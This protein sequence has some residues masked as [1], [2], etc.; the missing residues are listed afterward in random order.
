MDKAKYK[1]VLKGLEDLEE[2]AILKIE[3]DRDWRVWEVVMEIV[4][5]VLLLVAFLVMIGVVGFVGVLLLADE[6]S[7]DDIYDWKVKF[8]KSLAW[9]VTFGSERLHLNPPTLGGVSKCHNM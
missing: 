6:E 5:K 3:L 4:L 8:M 2:E 1:K 7:S 9:S